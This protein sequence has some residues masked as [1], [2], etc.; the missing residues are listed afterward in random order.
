MKKVWAYVIGSGL[1][2]FELEKLNAVGLS[3]VN[4]WTAH[5]NKLKAAFDIYGKQIIL[6]TVDEANY[7]ASGCSIDKL[8]RFIKQ[9]E[10][11]FN[12]E[13]LNRMNIAYEWNGGIAICNVSDIKS[14]LE[15]GQIDGKTIIFNTS[16]SNSEE[17]MAWRQPLESTWLK[18]Y[19]IKT[20]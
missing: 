20:A 4:Q 19:L 10:A 15:D 17:L 8:Q 11:E 12:C 5:E 13:L 18:K 6:I 2:D 7:G 14:L 1:S 3:F 16:I 9:C